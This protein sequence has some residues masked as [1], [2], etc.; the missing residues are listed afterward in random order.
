MYIL[1]NSVRNITR[2]KGRNF[3]I[4]IILVVIGAACAITLAIRQSAN[5]IVSSYEKEN[6][7]TATISFDR[8]NMM[9]SF[10]ESEKSQEEMINAFNDIESLSLEEIE[11]Y[12]DSKY[13]EKLTY[14]Y[15]INVNA[16]D[17]TEATDSLVKEKTEVT[18]KTT[19]KKFSGESGSRPGMPPMMD[20]GFRTSSQTTK[21]TTEKIYNEKKDSGA[22]NLVGYDSYETMKEFV[23]GSY[24]ITDGKVSGDFNGT[25]VIISEELATLNELKVGDKITL[26]DPK[27]E[28]LTYE[29]TITGIYKENSD[30]AND[31]GSM[32]S[33][34]ANKIIT[35]SNFIKTILDADEDLSATIT[36]TFIL[37]DKNSVEGFEKEVKEKG[38]GE[39][40][41]VSNNLSEI[42]GATKSVNNVKVFATTFLI[43][44][45]AIGAVVLIVVNMIN[46]R[47]RK[48]EIGVLRTIGMKKSKLSIQFI[49]EL[50]IVGIIS[51]LIGT[52][53]GA[54]LSVPIS[55]KLL[56]NEINSAS[57]KYE[58][59]ENNFGGAGPDMN[60]KGQDF[61]VAK[62]EEV[63]KINAVV[64]Y[65]VT[66]KLM[67]IGI[68]LILISSLAST[69]VIQ[70]FSPLTILKER[71]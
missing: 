59:I 58:N 65:K 9:N 15:D 70:R 23:D 52:G 4:G 46:I 3:L 27:N 6:K 56:K 14:T 2:N 31:L 35:N 32:F 55:N 61:G 29:A 50:L 49:C 39:F 69:V 17:I 30:S 12:A 36:P 54:T 45:L 38:L 28:K 51:L 37:K 24:T 41:T 43:I 47:E 20:G 1:K 7:L 26:V 8:R 25:D 64:D 68:G 42:E 10:R 19:T 62:V 44:T 53:V 16:K 67:L 48:Y 11:K 13:V 34:S 21:K 63:S 66:G 22:F 40:Y 18:T 5:N 71:S 57:E 60:F 33:N